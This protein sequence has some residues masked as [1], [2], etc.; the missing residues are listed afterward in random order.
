MEKILSIII[1]TKNRQEYCIAA[2]KHICEL[3]VRTDFEIVIQDNSDDDSLRQ[4]VASIGDKRVIYNYH[5]GVLSFVDNFSEGFEHSCGEYVCYIGD[6]DTVLPVIFG[7]TDFL[8]RE[9]IDCFVP[10]LSAIYFWPSKDKILNDCKGRGSLFY[11]RKG[12]KKIDTL[13]GLKK[14]ARNGGQNYQ[15]LSLARSYHGIVK[16]ESFEKVKN[17]TGHYFDGLSPDIYNAVTLSIVSKNVVRGFF[18]VTISGICSKSGS[19]ASA[20]GKHTGKLDEAPH[21]K[22]HNN[23]IWDSKIAYVYSVETIWAETVVHALKAMGAEDSYNDFN[24]A[25]LIMYTLKNNKSIREEV[26]KY[27]K[28]NSISKFRLLC[29]QIYVDLVRILE[30]LKK[31]FITRKNDRFRFNDIN[32]IAD[33]ER[34]ISKFVTDEH[35]KSLNVK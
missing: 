18:P 34:I 9:D 31:L 1:P 33:A 2:I 12:C 20:T 4:A 10:S 11:V 22:G 19:A 25:K 28:D 15:S 32:N 5:G 21:F 3:S 35:V 7:V 6:D 13:N 8:K 14:L 29:S 27:C 16:R 26:L 17:I 30:K 24:V 23:Y